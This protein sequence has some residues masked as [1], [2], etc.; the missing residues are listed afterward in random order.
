MGKVE[1]KVL[2]GYEVVTLSHGHQEV[3]VIP[4]FGGNWFSWKLDGRE[5]R[6]PYRF[7]LPK[8]LFGTPVLFPSPNRLKN[9][10]Y[11][12]E[13]RNYQMVKDGAPRVLHGV[14]LDEPL[15]TD[16]WGAD[17]NEAH[18]TLRADFLPGTRLY[19]MFPF[20][21]VFKLHYSLCK[22]G[23]EISYTGENKGAGK[24]PFGFAVHPS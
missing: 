5:L 14:I 21:C 2:D 9:G 17:E 12:F 10:E 20:A 11:T 22:L 23:L 7:D 13:G 6:S 18:L 8:D 24:M 3:S 4:S 1:W 16:G 19:D 15:M